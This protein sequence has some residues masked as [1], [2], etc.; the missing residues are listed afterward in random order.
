MSNPN[1]SL[2][3]RN[4]DPD[5]GDAYDALAVF[6]EDREREARELAEHYVQFGLA[7]VGELAEHLEIVL[8]RAQVIGFDLAVKPLDTN[9]GSDGD[10]Q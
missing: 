4:G 3:R 10:R 2:L 6:D 1:Y 5:C 8:H 7:D 9:G